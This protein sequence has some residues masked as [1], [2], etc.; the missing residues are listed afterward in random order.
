MDTIRDY[1][2]KLRDLGVTMVGVGSHI[3]EVL[4]MVE[5]QGWDWA[6]SR[7]SRTR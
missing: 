3:P 4:A 1:C 7:E 2:R 6:C 5:E